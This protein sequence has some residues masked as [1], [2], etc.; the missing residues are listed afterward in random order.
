MTQS[1]TKPRLFSLAPPLRQVEGRKESTKLL[2]VER[3]SRS[4]KKG[5]V[6]EITRSARKKHHGDAQAGRGARGLG[7]KPSKEATTTTVGKIIIFFA[8]TVE[9]AVLEKGRAGVQQPHHRVGLRHNRGA[10]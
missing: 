6:A 10:T 4:Q 9:A 2:T 3:K 1:Y 8:G 7:G 5:E